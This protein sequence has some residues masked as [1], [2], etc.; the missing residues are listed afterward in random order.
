MDF[1][2]I[3]PYNEPHKCCWCGGYCK[4]ILRIGI[5]VPLWQC[6]GEKCLTE[7]KKLYFECKRENNKRYYDNLPYYD[8]NELDEYD[9]KKYDR[10]QNLK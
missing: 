5:D 9:N 7:I 3:L 10:D 6:G 2:E 4:E 8:T 1:F